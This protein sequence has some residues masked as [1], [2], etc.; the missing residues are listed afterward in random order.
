MMQLLHFDSHVSML[1]QYHDKLRCL[2]DTLD[3]AD[4]RPVKSLQDFV[5][6]VHARA[7]KAG[8]EGDMSQRAE[9]MLSLVLD[10]K[11]N[12]RRDKASGPAAVL[13][14]AVV[15]WL[16]QCHVGHVQ[17]KGLTWNKLL[18]SSKKVRHDVCIFRQHPELYKDP[19][20]LK[21]WLCSTVLQH[22][23]AGVFIADEG[24]VPLSHS[25]EIAN[26]AD[27]NDHKI[28]SAWMQTSGPLAV[29][30]HTEC[31]S[32]E[33][34]LGKVLVSSFSLQTGSFLRKYFSTMT[35]R[36]GPFQ[37]DA[38]SDNEGRNALCFELWSP[39][40][41]YT[42]LTWGGKSTWCNSPFDEVQEVLLQALGRAKIQRSCRL[43][44]QS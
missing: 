37:L 6:A 34:S 44:V 3:H 4:A 17:L 29:M 25:L 18:T 38:T 28:S 31:H 12:K 11:N 33:T 8:S 9:I 15:T 14:P 23:I 22:T 35:L 32:A 26:K 1:P 10:I 5:V 40:N 19:D 27:N 24:L 21:A 43:G 39:A 20:T 30:A 36:Y 41:S 2:T 7:A 16:K 42:N 13:S